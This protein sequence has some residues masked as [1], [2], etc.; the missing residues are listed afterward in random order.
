MEKECSVYKVTYKRVIEG[1]TIS[2]NALEVI[3]YGE[4]LE[5]IKQ[6]LWETK[7]DFYK[8]DYEFKIIKIERK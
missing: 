3:I 5:Q 4:D 2:P 1:Y 7:R 6:R 8:E